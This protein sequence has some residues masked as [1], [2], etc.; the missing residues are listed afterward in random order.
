M[1]PMTTRSP[2]AYALIGL[3]ATMLLG[4]C[5]TGGRPSVEIAAEP[6]YHPDS[7]G[8]MDPGATT[9]KLAGA[10]GEVLG[11]HLTVR[12][13]GNAAVAA[14]R[15]RSSKFQSPK[16]TI[17]ASAVEIF[18]LH[19]VSVDRWPGWHIRSIPVAK[20]DPAPLDVLVPLDAPRGGMPNM[21]SP[22]V[23]YHFWADVRIPMGVPDGTYR[24]RI[25]LLSGGREIR[26]I[27]IEL[28]VWP[29]VLPRDIGFD[30]IAELDHAALAA[31]HLH[32]GRQ[33][34]RRNGLSPI[35]TQV[36]LLDAVR[37]MRRHRVAG[38]YPML[39][40]GVG[41]TGSTNLSLDWELFDEVVGPILSGKAF[42]DRSPTK[43]WPV[44]VH[45]SLPLTMNE[46]N[47]RRRLLSEYLSGAIKHFREREWDG[48]L[49]LLTRDPESG[50]SVSPR[51]LATLIGPVSDQIQ[52]VS[53]VPVQNLAPFGWT[54]YPHQD[55]GD[56]VNEWAPS[57][58]FFDRNAAARELD[59]GKATWFC[60]DRPPFSGSLEVSAPPT[61]A[62]VL[63][64]QAASVDASQLYLGRVLQWPPAEQT[65]SPSRCASAHPANLLYPGTTFGMVEPVMSLRLKHLRRGLQDVA[66]LR[67]LRE[68]GRS[69]IADRVLSSIIRYVGTG[70]FD[71]HYGDGSRIGWPMEARAFDAAR[72]VM[73]EEMLRVVAS[74]GEDSDSGSFA[75]TAAWRRFNQ[76]THRTALVAEGVRMRMTGSP[77]HPQVGISAYVGLEYDS[78]DGEGGAFRLDNW[79]ATWDVGATLET[80]RHPSAAGLH[81]ISIETVVP[82]AAVSFAGSFDLAGIAEFDSG[83]RVTT[84]IPVR[85]VTAQ[86]CDRPPLIDGDL[87]DWPV[88]TTNVAAN[89][90]SI[91]GVFGVDGSASRA[92]GAPTLAFL[93]RDDEYLYVAI[94]A[95][96]PKAST[97]ESRSRKAVTYDDTIPVGEEL[98]ELL[99]DPLNVA[100]RS[101]ESIYHIVI[102][103]SGSDLSEKGIDFDPP[104]GERTPWA[105]DADVAVSA[106]VDRWTAEVRIPLS[107]FGTGPF[108]NVFWGF[109]VTRFDIEGNEYSTWS[110][111]EGNA[112][113]PI[114]FGN[115]LLLP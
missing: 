18:R 89:F 90:Q 80:F 2:F 52:L 102:K 103:R 78:V 66:Y 29:I 21:L 14:P 64:W 38:V 70:A 54:G 47:S 19:A 63:A 28:T 44:P 113:D 46:S 13:S 77:A 59:V 68:H 56:V 26:A 24:S 108:R 34:N 105:G 1:T 20:R 100:T 75:R 57:A 71:A 65:P 87:S 107:S 62:R 10:I 110:A 109:N 93:M 39:A 16:G 12:A 98:I 48:R 61:Y 74:G 88:G 96:T 73:A 112:Y 50:E 76:L 37:Q 25:T 95:S 85:C 106:A 6:G 83:Q 4:G 3:I 30:T 114:S 55:I 111:S 27:D 22:G 5:R 42:Q 60:A 35:D 99:F 86:R 8:S 23:T 51:D 81:R 115:L 45:V 7:T 104:V 58:Q 31:H 92:A 17:S 84:S 36:I 53:T 101:P 15:L 97:A 41:I 94:N 67:L 91:A 82:L 72:R 69:A 11:V 40:P 49:Y 43:R 79:P 32:G 33:Q 9:I